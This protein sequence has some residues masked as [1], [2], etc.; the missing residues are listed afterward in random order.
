[1]V[2]IKELSDKFMKEIPFSA[3]RSRPSSK[4]IQFTLDPNACENCSA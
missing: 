3:L 4:A 2:N 1:M